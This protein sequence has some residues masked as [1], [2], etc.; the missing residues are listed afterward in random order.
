MKLAYFDCQFGAAGDMLLAALLD[1]GAHQE[2]WL[3]E[4][5]KLALPKN[6][7]QIA[8]KRIERSSIDCL[9]VDVI[10]PHEHAHRHLSDIV[11]IIGKS[12]IA[13]AAKDLAVKIFQRLAK[14]E[15]KVHGLDIEEVHFHEVG[16]IDAI[17]D[18]VGFA[19]AYTLL[20]IDEARVSALPLGGGLIE[21]EHGK[22]PAPGPAVLNLLSQAACPIAESDI[23]FECLTPTGA[24]ILTTIA[25]SWGTMPSMD[26][27][28]CSG[29][30]AGSKNTPGWPNAC[31]VVVG[32][33]KVKSAAEQRFDTD[34][35]TVLE[36]NLDDCSPQ[37]IAYAAEKL[38]QHGA[39]D[40]AVIPAVMKKGRSG[41]LINVLCHCEDAE[42]L[43]AIMMTETSTLGV[44][45]HLSRRSIANR[46]WQE[47]DLSAGQSVRVKLAYDQSGLALNAQPEFDDCAR[48][49]TNNGV[50]L[51]E[52]SLQAL[53]KLQRP[54]N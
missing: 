36:A 26:R 29:H 43:I 33:A 44:R 6:S 39:L 46:Q 14:A 21:M 2:A 45:Q 35:V 30:G 47:V 51:K 4:V 42:R 41:H 23:N 7:F 5:G 10:C 13:P 8:I 1:A 31:R 49:A 40:V 16:A 37:V 54:E 48:Y 12:D 3:K 25:N 18:I 9:K 53:A 27:M 19:I 22:L 17:V 11:D 28:L 38:L 15:A 20:E 52:V 34:M 24:A 50:P 32:E